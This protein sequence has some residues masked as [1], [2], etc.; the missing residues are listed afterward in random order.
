MIRAPVK[1]IINSD[2]YFVC[3]VFRMRRIIA[4]AVVFGGLLLSIGFM[5]APVSAA[6]I[7]TVTWKVTSLTVGET[8]RLTDIAESDSTGRKTWSTS[9]STSGSCSLTPAKNPTKLKMGNKGGC[10]LTLRIAESDQYE[11]WQEGRMILRK[12]FSVKGSRI[13][14]D[15]NLSYANLKGADL[16]YADLSYA[17]LTGANL[18]GA[19][20]KGAFL[21]GADLSYAN[22]Y[23]ANLDLAVLY[24]AELYETNLW[25]ADLKHANLSY[26]NLS[27]A[28]LTDAS[29]W[30]ANLYYSWLPYANLSWA[31]LSYA[32]LTGANLYLANL[33]FTERQGAT[34]PEGWRDTVCCY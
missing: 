14:P 28:N 15:A 1:F 25:G 21:W 26:A 19:N 30:G 27:Y 9:G 7:P 17:N 13:R 5:S 23:D 24:D 10:L 33:K 12:G 18:K 3:R 2:P 8:H 16:S 20:L 31:D 32:D 4:I 34:M 6:A 11:A 29:L 22:L